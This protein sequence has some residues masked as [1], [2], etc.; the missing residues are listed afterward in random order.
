MLE[1]LFK[2]WSEE[3]KLRLLEVAVDSN[4]SE[5]IAL[6]LYLPNFKKEY[7]LKEKARFEY[8]GFTVQNTHNMP[9]NELFIDK[10]NKLGRSIYLITTD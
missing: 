5:K 6:I 2:S 9:P 8:Y 3:N 10:N 1:N 4:F 7:F